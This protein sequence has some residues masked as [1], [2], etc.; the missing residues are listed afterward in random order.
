TSAP[1]D[2]VDLNKHPMVIF[3]EV[4][5]GTNPVMGADVRALITLPDAANATD[6]I[7]IKL[8]DSGSDPD[9]LQGDG[10]Y[11]RYLTG[12]T[13]T[14]R[15]IVKAE[16]KQGNN[17]IINKGSSTSKRKKRNLIASE[18]EISPDRCC[19]SFVPL[20]RIIGEP[21]GNFSRSEVTGSVKITGVPDP[22]SDKIPPSKIRDLTVKNTERDDANISVYYS[23]FEWTAPGDDLDSG[24]VNNYSLFFTD[25]ITNIYKEDFSLIRDYEI[26]SEIIDDILQE[27]GT[28]VSLNISLELSTFLEG[29]PYFFALI[30]EDEKGNK[31]PVSNIVW[32]ILNPPPTEQ[33]MVAPYDWSWIWIYILIGV[34]VLIVLGIIFGVWCRHRSKKEDEL[35]LDTPSM[36]VDKTQAE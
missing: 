25:N 13:I 29:V 30:A 5:Q 19:G 10:I 16:V 7:E 36:W 1:P 8:L 28:K 27:A 14:G 4:K 33:P 32:V 2:G 11:S 18:S 35:P 20:G 3:A 6:P 17:S 34:G 26:S 21:T 15:I 9:T 23:T 12:V 31:S 24:I 22:G